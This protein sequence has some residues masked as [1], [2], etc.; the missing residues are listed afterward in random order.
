METSSIISVGV[1]NKMLSLVT[2]I[3]LDLQ[4]K[5]TIVNR[6]I[7]DTGDVYSLQKA[8]KVI[9][10]RLDEIEELGCF[11]EDIE[12]GIIDF[13]SKIDDERVMLC[14]RLGEEEILHYHKRGENAR[15]RLLINQVLE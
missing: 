13:P 15:R 1:A 12:K 10:R 14:W 8:I 6:N 3:V 7:G 4:E 11:L 9:C 2:P 5:W